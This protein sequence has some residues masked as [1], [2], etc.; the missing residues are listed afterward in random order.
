MLHS[1]IL[2]IKLINPPSL[3]PPVSAPLPFLL[4]TSPPPHQPRTGQ[5]SRRFPLAPAS[6]TATTERV[7]KPRRRFRPGQKSPTAAR[8][9]TSDFADASDAPR[10]ASPARKR[11]WRPSP[12]ISWALCLGWRGRHMQAAPPAITGHAFPRICEMWRWMSID[13]HLSSSLSIFY[14]RSAV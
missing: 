10:P 9:Q 14:S 6:Q 8:P 4:Q 2:L 3:L 11:T 12:A 1:H 7:K 13:C 5:T